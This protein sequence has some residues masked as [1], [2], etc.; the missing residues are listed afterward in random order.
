MNNIFH[1]EMAIV[2]IRDFFRQ[3][4]WRSTYTFLGVC[5]LRV[6]DLVGKLCNEHFGDF[7]KLPVWRPL[8]LPALQW[9]S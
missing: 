3:S 4:S 8:I 1:R 2:C 7:L 6:G 9:L 5:F